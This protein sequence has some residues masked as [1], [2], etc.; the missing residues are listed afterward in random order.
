MAHYGLKLAGGFL[1]FLGLW[2]GSGYLMWVLL[3]PFLEE[4]DGPRGGALL[5]A[6]FVFILSTSALW[7]VVKA[8][9]H[10]MNEGEWPP[11][12]WS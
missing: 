12:G 5:V 8:V 6:G 4:A 9:W 2:L 1:L 11:E 10:R 3:P 7:W